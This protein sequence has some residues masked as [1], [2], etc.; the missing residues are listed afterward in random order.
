MITAVPSCMG[1]QELGR[2]RER[3][4]TSAMMLR[5]IN[6]SKELPDGSDASAEEDSEDEKP[7]K[8]KQKRSKKKDDSD[9][10]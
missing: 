2:Q 1:G 3:K 6:N 4:L 9:S 7:K 5:Q 10:D 8:K